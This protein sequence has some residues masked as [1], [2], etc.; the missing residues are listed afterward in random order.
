ME[1]A[2]SALG[3]QPRG[4][5]V[6]LA[7]ARKTLNTEEYCRVRMT[8]QV[9]ADLPQTQDIQLP[10]F[11]NAAW[12]DSFGFLDEAMFRDILDPFGTQGFL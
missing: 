5:D 3:F 11:T 9:P 4:S 7:C 1:S 6:F 8:G 12:D 2:S 10:D